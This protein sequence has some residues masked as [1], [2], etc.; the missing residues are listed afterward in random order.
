MT[1]DEA[2]ARGGR[3]KSPLKMAATARNLERAK[4]V[5]AEKRALKVKK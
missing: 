1:I 2:G 5:L 3:S 4:K